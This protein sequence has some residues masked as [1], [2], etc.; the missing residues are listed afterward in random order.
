[1]SAD[2]M[3]API[4]R[5]RAE[6]IEPR[7]RGA[8]LGGE[9]VVLPTDTVYG[10]GRRRVPPG[11]GDRPARGQGP[12]PGHAAAGA[13][14]LRARGDRADR[15]PRRRTAR[16]DRRVLAGR[17]HPGLPG[18]PVADLGSGRHQ[19]HG[20]GPDAAAPGRARAAQGDRPAGGEQRQPTGQP[21]ATTAAAARRSS[22]ATRV[23]CTW[24]A[25]RASST[26]P[27]TIVDLTGDVPRLLR[28]G[29]VSL[30]RLRE[31][32]AV[33]SVDDVGSDA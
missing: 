12:G 3:T 6:G 23:A 21:P 30:D 29:A 5:Q 10:R 26:S 18:Q 15:G 9:L 20:R 17:P 32:A 1:M 4:R 2:G 7:R 8:A 33:A 28:A 24:T 27:S 31:V 13:G 16:T 14:R 19:G 22:S 25:A 11:R